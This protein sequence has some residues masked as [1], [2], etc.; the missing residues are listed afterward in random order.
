MAFGDAPHD[1]EAK[2]GAAAS[3]RGAVAVKAL[4]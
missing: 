3:P 4:E 1:V 2:S